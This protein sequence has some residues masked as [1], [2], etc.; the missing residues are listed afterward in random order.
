[1]DTYL[2]SI[3]LCDGQPQHLS[4]HQERLART[5]HFLGQPATAVPILSQHLPSALPMGRCKWRIVYSAEGVLSSE[6]QP[7]T[8][9]PTH[10]LCLVEC[11]SIT[12]THKSTD[13]SALEACYA[14][15]HGADDVLITRHGLITDTTIA[16]VALYDGARWY[17]P[18]T[19][20]LAG[21]QRQYLLEQGLLHE[22]ALL[23]SAIGEYTHIALFNAMLP[24][25]EVVLPT[26]HI[27]NR[28]TAI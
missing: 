19:P 12:Y 24:W 2:E 17:T 13:R 15:R 6:V 16:N 28:P 22:R 10:T 18:S 14:Q 20:L 11:P 1:M 8:P 3:C 26:S 4:L 25:G 23:A 27:I 9:R 21:V 5:W 7:Y